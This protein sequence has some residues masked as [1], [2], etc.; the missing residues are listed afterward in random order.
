MKDERKAE[1]K[2][3]KVEHKL[4]KAVGKHDDVAAH[5][6]KASAVRRHA[7]AALHRDR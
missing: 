5:E 2:H 4:E 1:K 6:N 3:E 7:M